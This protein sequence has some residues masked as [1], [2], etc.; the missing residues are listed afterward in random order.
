M[1]RA[2]ASQT[3]V[4]FISTVERPTEMF[5][6]DVQSGIQGSTTW[7]SAAKGKVPNKILKPNLLKHVLV[8]KTL[9]IELAPTTLHFTTSLL[10]RPQ[11]ICARLR[12]AHC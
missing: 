5:Y 10:G 6:K 1:N 12:R 7:H 9:L 4:Q 8:L 2:S 3:W 11:N